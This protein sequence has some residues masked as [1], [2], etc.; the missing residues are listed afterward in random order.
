[1]LVDLGVILTVFWFCC[2]DEFAIWGIVGNCFAGLLFVDFVLFCCG[3]FVVLLP[4]CT[5]VVDAC[6]VIWC[7]VFC[8]F[9]CWFGLL[10]VCFWFEC[11]VL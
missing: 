6:F 4:W 10:M 11:L 2:F 5:M 9:A 1:M 7:L 3:C 8:G